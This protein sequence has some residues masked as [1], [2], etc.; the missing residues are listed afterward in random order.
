MTVADPEQFTFKGNSAIYIRAFVERFNERKRR[1]IHKI[2]EM[3]RF[4]KIH[5]STC[6]NPCNL[7]AHWI[8]EISS[9]LHS[10][11]VIPR[12]Q[13]KFVFY[14]NNHIDWDQFN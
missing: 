7:G 5:T 9:V 11:Y 3:I 1:Q 2:H 6:K 4:D 13:D 8:I 14:V 12:N 10:T